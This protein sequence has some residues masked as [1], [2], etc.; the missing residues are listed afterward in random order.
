M[1][2]GLFLPALRHVV[3]PQSAGASE[4]PLDPLGCIMGSE[5]Q[6]TAL[7]AYMT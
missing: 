5:L 7:H 3:Q 2:R 4:Y 1:L 6:S